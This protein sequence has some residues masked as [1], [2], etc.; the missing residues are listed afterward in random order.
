MS[1]AFGLYAKYYNLL[2][3]D[4]DYSAEVNYVA[5]RVK[6]FA[7]EAEAIL[8]LGSGT[9]GHGLLLEKK[10]FRLHGLERSEEMVK[11]AREKGFSCE[12]K[13]ITSFD[14]NR[15]FDAVISLFHVISYITDNGKLIDVFTNAGNHLHQGGI[16]LFDIW[17]TPAVY[18]QKALPRMKKMKNDEIEVTRF[19][20]PRIDIN[21][22]MVDVQYTVFA[23]ETGTGNYTEIFE[24]HPM[25]HFSIPEIGLLAE[26]TGF[27]MLRS[28]EFG[29]GNEPS[30]GTWGVCF[31]LGK[32]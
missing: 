7:P 19:A 29:T 17:Y 20:E 18:E 10:G 32:K 12:V 13:D 24:S 16:F 11:A 27:Q 9:G 25:R 8:E 1:D 21:K 4:K 22:N 14:L 31:I 30:A 23:K 15:K 5:A 28:E 6:E 2:Y 3:S 26:L